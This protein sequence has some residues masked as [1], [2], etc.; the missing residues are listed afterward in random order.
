L[1]ILS[2]MLAGIAVAV[3]VSSG[4]P[5]LFRQVR[6][7]R[8]GRRFRLL[9]FRSMR[10]NRQVQQ[11]T[12]PADSRITPLGAILRRYK[13]DEL[14]QLWNVLRG[15]MSMVGPRPEVPRFVDPAS[16]AWRRILSVRPGI[17]DLATLLFRDEEKL[18][19]GVGD[20][21]SHYRK[22][23]LPRKMALNIEYLDARSLLSDLRVLLLTLVA[24]FLRWPLDPSALRRKMRMARTV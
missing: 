14:P 2:P 24:S 17:T 9:K 23:I 1:L 12:S 16:E 5:V 18:L 22:Q 13:L 21:E 4:R 7:G 19:A 11:I 20:V 3:L 8:Y 15:E 6:V 10:V